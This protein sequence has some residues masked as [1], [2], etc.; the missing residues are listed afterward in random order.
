MP[1][2]MVA[3][4]VYQLLAADSGESGSF[5]PMPGQHSDHAGPLG[6]TR[7]TA[8]SLNEVNVQWPR[9]RPVGAGL[10]FSDLCFRI[11]LF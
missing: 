1:R 2:G 6:K 7:R 9:L 10:L 11:G 3:R 4:C 5:R 8:L